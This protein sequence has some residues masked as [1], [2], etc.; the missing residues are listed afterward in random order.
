MIGRASDRVA[1]LTIETLAQV[2]FE[3][4]DRVASL[5]ADVCASYRALAVMAL[6]ALHG[7]TVEHDQRARAAP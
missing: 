7:L 2:E 6:D 1:E 4:R 5:E 3:L